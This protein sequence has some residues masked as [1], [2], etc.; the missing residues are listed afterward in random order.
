MGVQTVQICSLRVAVL[1]P[2]EKREGV[3][4]A[5]RRL[6]NMSSVRLGGLVVTTNGQRISTRLVRTSCRWNRTHG[7]KSCLSGSS[8]EV[9]QTRM[10][11][12]EF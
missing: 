6:S 4:T 7:R 5:T 2:K 1:T 3:G 11:S 12:L 8:E 10:V 9:L